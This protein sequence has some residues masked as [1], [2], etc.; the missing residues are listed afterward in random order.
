[1]YTITGSTPVAPAGFTMR[2]GTVPVGPPSTVIHVSLTSGLSMGLD[3]TS[4]TTDRHSA[5]GIS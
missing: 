1:M 2:T 5:G 3:W 4:S